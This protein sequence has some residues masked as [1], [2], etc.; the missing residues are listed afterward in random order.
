MVRGIGDER[1][2]RWLRRLN[3]VK[4]VAAQLESSRRLGL[5]NSNQ[6]VEA[7]FKDLKALWWARTGS[8][9]NA[10]RTN[11]LLKLYVL[12]GQG[13]DGPRQ[14]SLVIRRHLGHLQGIGEPPRQVTDKGA[15]PAEVMG[16]RSSLRAL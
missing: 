2:D 6:S 8:Y 15:K 1:T 3:R 5:P 4:R 10:E 9:R 13:L 7:Y 12:R 11:R 16:A 14:Y